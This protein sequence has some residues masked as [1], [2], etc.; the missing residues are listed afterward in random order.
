[1]S[2]PTNLIEAVEYYSDPDVCHQLMIQV[3]WP[4]GI[5]CPHCG[6][7]GDRIGQVATRRLIRCKDCRKQISTKK[8]TIFEDSPLPLQKWF[9]AIWCV[10]NCKNGISSHE[11]G[12]ALGIRQA[13]AWH[14]LHRIRKAMEAGGFDKQDGDHEADTTYVGGKAKNMHKDKRLTY[15]LL[16]NQG[17]AGF[18][19]IA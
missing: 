11:L 5:V 7:K 18:M 17:D 8:D 1:M 2:Q 19:G 9:V 4:R 10:A 15:R 13:S 6:A 16:T 14:M 3:K 12:R